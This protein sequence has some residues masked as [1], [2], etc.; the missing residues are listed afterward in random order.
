M[1]KLIPI[2]III[3][4]LP[5]VSPT[6]TK[7]H[8]DWHE[9]SGQF[10]KEG[11]LYDFQLQQSDIELLRFNANE[12]STIIRKGT[13]QKNAQYTYC[14]EDFDF[15]HA[16]AT[17]SARGIY[18][19]A[20]KILIEKDTYEPPVKESD[21]KI[22]L[23]GSTRLEAGETGTVTL[24]LENAGETQIQGIQTTITIPKDLH[25]ETK[26]LIKFE[27]TL[28]STT[29]N[30]R[31]GDDYTYNIT[32]QA[33]KSQTYD[34]S[35][36]IKY[37]SSGEQQQAT[38][39][40]RIEV[41][42]PYTFQ[43][44]AVTRVQVGET[45][46]Y[47]YTLTNRL[48]EPITIKSNLQHPTSL[49]PLRANNL[50]LQHGTRNYQDTSTLSAGQSKTFQVTYRQVNT[51]NSEL[52]GNV[53]ITALG[54]KYNESL[55]HAI[56]TSSDTL[57]STLKVDRTDI[58]PNTPYRITYTLTN[59]NNNLDIT[60]VETRL[61]G[62]VNKT[63]TTDVRRGETKTIID[64]RL[65]APEIDQNIAYQINAT[66]LYR[67]SG[68]LNR[69]EDTHTINVIGDDTPIVISTRPSNRIVAP[70]D[71]I[72][73]IVTIRNVADS[74]LEAMQVEDSFN[75][76]VQRVAGR[77][78]NTIS[79]QGKQQSQA[80]TYEIEIP[81]T[82]NQDLII[83]TVAVT[84]NYQAIH[85]TTIEVSGAEQETQTGGATEPGSSTTQPPSQQVDGEIETV[86]QRQE[87][88]GFMQTYRKFTEFLRGLFR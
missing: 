11:I 7:I 50:Q 42:K 6:V 51:Q 63:I 46:Q 47:Q 15:E 36:Q 1:K 58:L 67:V 56:Q 29:M 21:F 14:Y 64:E 3:L 49:I 57:T 9:Y 18:V 8:E 80:Y 55:N 76:D 37:S 2:L 27:T 87:E 28:Q 44:Q 82:A 35:A 32:I 22:T 52:R 38:R 68:V 23:T 25:V 78:Q 62:I 41:P 59:R 86:R 81:R 43:K 72:Q 53:E 31:P 74:S 26:D 19:P 17:I 60:G 83:T 39:T 40:L 13:C 33:N 10:T 88:S 70:G 30:L 5:V 45:F 73:M 20:I 79:L 71:R 54:H 75:Q 48:D 12:F 77:T 4:L 84:Q 69:L 16:K 85:N 24:K 66:T 65:I 34:L 61:T